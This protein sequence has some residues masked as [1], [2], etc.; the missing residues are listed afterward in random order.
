MYGQ[1]KVPVAYVQDKLMNELRSH[2]T[3]IPTGE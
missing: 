3:F 2:S 1:Q